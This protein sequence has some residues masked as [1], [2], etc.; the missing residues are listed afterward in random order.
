MKYLVQRV[1]FENNKSYQFCLRHG[2]ETFR[3]EDCYNC[4][5]HHVDKCSFDY[6]KT[7]DNGHLM[8]DQNTTFYIKNL[9][10]SKSKQAKH[11]NSYEIVSSKEI[12]SISVNSTLSLDY[13]IE[14]ILSDNQDNWSSEAFK[15]PDCPLIDL[16]VY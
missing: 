1:I 7:D 13:S 4:I 5:M 3:L 12:Q 16:I 11:D 9:E 6:I 15:Y 14:S 2:N 10:L 8:G